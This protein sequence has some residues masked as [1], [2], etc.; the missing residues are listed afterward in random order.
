MN[1]ILSVELSQIVKKKV[2][3]LC[4]QFP[5]T[6]WYIFRGMMMVAGAEITVKVTN[7]KLFLTI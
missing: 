6:I 2:A 5:F 3:R 1:E 7:Q 4:K